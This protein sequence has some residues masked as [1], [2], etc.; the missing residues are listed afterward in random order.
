MNYKIDA[1]LSKIEDCVAN[2]KTTILSKDNIILNKSELIDSLHELRSYLDDYKNSWQVVNDR[3]NTEDMLMLINHKRK[4]TKSDID[5][6]K[7]YVSKIPCRDFVYVCGTGLGCS[8]CPHYHLQLVLD[9]I[10]NSDFC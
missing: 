6:V 9:E 4:V 7:D 2:G 8:N 3:R 10:S 1:L 5:M